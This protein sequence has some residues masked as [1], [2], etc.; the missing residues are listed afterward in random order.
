MQFIVL[1]L[2]LVPLI[3]SCVLKK[4]IKREKVGK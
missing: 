3:L 4:M 1:F 2:T